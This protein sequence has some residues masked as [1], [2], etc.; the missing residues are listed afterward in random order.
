[1]LAML[2]LGLVSA[3]CFTMASEAHARNDSP[4]SAA[5]SM[6]RS[7]SSDSGPEI[8]GPTD[9]YYF[10][11]AWSVSRREIYYTRPF[12][13]YRYDRIQIDHAW[14]D[15]IRVHREGVEPNSA[16]CSHI[17]DTLPAISMIQSMGFTAI[18]KELSGNSRS[19]PRREEVSWIYGE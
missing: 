3:F 14:Q 16:V 5:A 10:C 15:W 7:S 11:R 4:T 9:E 17:R 2:R 18:N 12:I 8:L 6:S 19:S 13:P 1:M